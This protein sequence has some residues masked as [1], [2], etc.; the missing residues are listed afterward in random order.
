[1][2]SPDGLPHSGFLRA[3]RILSLQPGAEGDGI[4][5]SQG[6]IRAVGD[7]V[8]LGRQVPTGVPR[9]D[10]P[11]ALV[12]PGFVDGHTHFGFWALNRRR[13][14]LAGAVNREDALRR[15]G[16][17]IPE[18]GWLRGH[19]WDANRWE[20][21]PDRWALD[22]VTAGPA[23]FESVDVHAGWTNSAGL[24]AAGINRDTPDPPGGRIVRDALGEPTGV[25]LEK[26]QE[27]I[28]RLL[29][30]SDPERMLAAMREAQG[31]AHRLGI[32]GIHDVEGPDALR[33][34][35]ALESADSLRL[36]VLFH[37]PVAQLATLLRHG[38]ASGRGSNWLTLGGIKLF[39]DGSLGSRTAWM[40]AP[41]EDGR[42][43]GMALATMD[44][45]RSAVQ[46]AARGAIS[47]T[48]HAIG[49]AAVRRALDLLE[50]LP[51]L[52]VPHRIEHFQCVHP[53]DLGRAAARGIAVSMQPAHLPED[54]SLAEE[55]WGVR[56]RGAYATKS[57]LRSG[58]ILAFGSD[59]PVASIDP[60]LGVAAAM[61]RIAADGSFPGGWYPDERLT[62]EEA[63]RGFTLGNAI[64]GGNAG[65]RGRLAPGYDAD[66]VAW[67]VDPAAEQAG[68]GAAFARGRAVLTVVGG[69]VVFSA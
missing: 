17:G 59:V 54:V 66:L 50:T 2:L 49:D 67:D 11:R 41:Y 43:S 48:V 24:L 36:R 31:E 68:E 16:L 1:V 26:A 47:A 20:G 4:W 38:V 28:Q 34:F 61:D 18:Q 46:A 51:V 64:A 22:E 7:A 15:I 55:R 35:R 19:G 5:W 8:D 58:A 69:E 65:R 57:L 60:R 13:V 6:A 56:G 10:L 42:D 53:D 12:T 40:L 32:T 62:L 39:L 45:A 29:P 9:F 3:R 23:F 37:P 33:A 14:H 21:A 63:V 27:L 52:A 25:L 44:E 30:K